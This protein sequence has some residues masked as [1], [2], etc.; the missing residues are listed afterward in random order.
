MEDSRRCK[1][2]EM[3]E[4]RCAT[5]AAAADEACR[6]LFGGESGASGAAVAVP[7]EVAKEWMAFLA[8]A[9]SLREDLWFIARPESKAGINN[10]GVLDARYQHELKMRRR[11]S[12]PIGSRAFSKL[13][14]SPVEKTKLPVL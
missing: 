14:A 2:S 9:I 4:Q 12:G 13:V 8:E 11:F 3:S 5:S 1:A 10:R 7:T 6:S